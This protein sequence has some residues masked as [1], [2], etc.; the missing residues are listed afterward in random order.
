L[1]EDDVALLVAELPGCLKAH[2]QEVDAIQYRIDAY[3]DSTSAAFATFTH[4]IATTL[5]QDFSTPQAQDNAPQ[6]R[7]DQEVCTALVEDAAILIRFYE[8]ARPITER[9]PLK[10]WIE[11]VKKIYDFFKSCDQEEWKSYQEEGI[12][13]YCFWR[14]QKIASQ[15]YYS[16]RDL[17]FISGLVDGVYR[18]GE[19]VLHLPDLV[20]D[21]SKF[22]GKLIY[23]YTLAYWECAPDH[24]LANY[25]EYEYTIEQ[26]AALE[27]E[28]GIWS[29][30]KEQWYDYKGKKKA[31]EKYFDDCHEA[32]QLRDDIE[33]LYEIISS[34]EEIGKL[35]DQVERKVKLYFKELDGTDNI[36]RYKQGR[37][38]VTAASAVLIIGELTRIS[39]IRAIL[40]NLKNATETQWN[41]FGEE[42]EKLKKG[43]GAEGVAKGADELVGTY[44]TTIKWGTKTVEARPFGNGYWGK[45]FPQ[46]NPRVDA[47][48]L[49][50]NPNNESYYLPL[51][52]ERMVQFEN[53]SKEAL[54]DGKL[55]ME[56]SSIYH[57]YD[58]PPVLRTNILNEAKD[59]AAV[60]KKYGLKVEWLVSDEKAVDHLTRFFKEE[61]VEI[62]V[63]LFPE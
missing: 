16:N 55:I 20:R 6:E 31:L 11:K 27:K 15:Y 36:N 28:G 41:K 58:K 2:S 62:I 22:P 3:E 56:K 32:E 4:R 39:K 19:G 48:E 1:Y 25:Q 17:A 10:E 43:K 12:V 33:H 24:L 35:Y 44:T 14:D 47:Y 9:G 37:F 57:V 29:W 50:I 53:I 7:V 21:L 51:S 23:A 45:R 63:K 30:V 42:L 18:E 52:E 40:R 34:W 49:K 54:Q 38:L 8:Q 61:N 5:A 13:P 59:Q 60:A 46:S 26:L